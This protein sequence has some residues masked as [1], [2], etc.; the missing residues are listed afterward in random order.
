M[1][2]QNNN[3]TNKNININNS[4][5]RGYPLNL[6]IENIQYNLNPVYKI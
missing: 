5:H 1:K 6:N 2:T 4:Y 3:N